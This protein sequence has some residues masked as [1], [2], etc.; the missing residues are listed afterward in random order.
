LTPLIDIV[1]LLLIYFMLAS[2]FVKEQQFHV[3]LPRSHHGERL[4]S[5]KAVITI[6]RQG[7]FFLNGEKASADAIEARLSSLAAQTRIEMVEIRSDRLAPVDLTIKAMD[8]AK[9][10]GLR[11]VLISTMPEGTGGHRH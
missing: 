11:R 7:E 9:G 3:E 6:S 8:A 1:F 5:A 10:A 4:K 2:N